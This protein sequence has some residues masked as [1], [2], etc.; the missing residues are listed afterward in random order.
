MMGAVHSTVTALVLSGI[1]FLRIVFVLPGKL[2]DRLKFIA[3]YRPRKGDDQ[4]LS[5]PGCWDAIQ[6]QLPGKPHCFSNLL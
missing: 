2:W 6:N 1:A 4:A 3:G 5:I